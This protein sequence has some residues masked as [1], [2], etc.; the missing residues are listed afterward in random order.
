MRCPGVEVTDKTV[1]LSRY[2]RLCYIS[3]KFSLHPIVFPLRSLRGRCRLRQMRCNYI[4]AVGATFFSEAHSHCADA[5]IAVARPVGADKTGICGTDKSVPYDCR[6]SCRQNRGDGR[7][8]LAPTWRGAR[9]SAVLALRETSRFCQQFRYR[10]TGDNRIRRC[11][12]APLK[13]RNRRACSIQ[14]A[15]QNLTAHYRVA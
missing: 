3:A 10:A 7:A 2:A 8:M 12:K 9:F 1:K 13:K 15:V 6:F 11:I 14:G 4:C 5:F